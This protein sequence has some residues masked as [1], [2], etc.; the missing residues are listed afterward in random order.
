MC[1]TSTQHQTKEKR[2]KTRKIHYSQSRKGK[3]MNRLV[4]QHV[5]KVKGK[6]AQTKIQQFNSTCCCA[7]KQG[8]ADEELCK[9]HKDRCVRVLKIANLTSLVVPPSCASLISHS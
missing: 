2:K 7:F 1:K 8:E 9:F 6:E 4:S 5:L 3:K